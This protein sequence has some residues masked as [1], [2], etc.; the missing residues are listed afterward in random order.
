VFSPP[1]LNPAVTSGCNRPFP[2]VNV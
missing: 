1:I 2:Y